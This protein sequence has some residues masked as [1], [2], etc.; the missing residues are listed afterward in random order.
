M[1]LSV[2]SMHPGA[3]SGRSTC[4]ARTTCSR[5]WTGCPRRAPY[6]RSRSAT[7]SATV[8]SSCRPPRTHIDAIACPLLVIQGQN[9]PRVVERESHD[10]VEHL[11]GIGKTVDYPV[12]AR[13]RARRA[14]ARE[15]RPLL[16]ADRRVLRAPVL[17]VRAP[18]LLA[19]CRPGGRQGATVAQIACT[20]SFQ[21]AWAGDG[22]ERL[23]LPTRCPCSA[24]SR[25]GTALRLL[26]VS[27]ISTPP[28]RAFLPAGHVAVR[29]FGLTEVSGLRR[30][31]LAGR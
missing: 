14:Q 9:D 26:P 18:E 28:P 30:D 13:T 1:T 23:A 3:G 8:T 2:V 27:L 17:V 4:S 16:R 5:S 12:F 15:P 21:L 25:R 20:T 7:P 6:S 11:R 22:L 31:P 24:C 10:L 19:C 29:F